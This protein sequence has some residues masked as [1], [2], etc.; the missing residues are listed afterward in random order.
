MGP[1]LGKN[2][3]GPLP[4]N[5]GKQENVHLR[6]SLLGAAQ[7]VFADPQ[8]LQGTQIHRKT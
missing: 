8:V 5:Q 4:E 3:R 7:T 2:T 1:R 6:R